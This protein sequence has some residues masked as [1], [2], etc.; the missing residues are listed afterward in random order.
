[1][2]YYEVIFIE[3]GGWGYLYF[4]HQICYYNSVNVGYMKGCDVMHIPKAQ[5]VLNL[6]GK[7]GLDILQRI[8]ELK[9][10]TD[11]EI[12]KKVKMMEEKLRK[13]GARI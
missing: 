6:R 4:R 5:Y 2:N 3:I 13:Q 8:A 7:R 10:E 9:P 1:M 11:E 12:E